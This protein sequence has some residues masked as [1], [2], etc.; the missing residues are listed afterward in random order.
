M[1]SGFDFAGID[2]LIDGTRTYA[3]RLIDAVAALIEGYAGQVVG[4]AKGGHPW[5]NRT[6]AAEAGLN[7]GVIREA[8]GEVVTLY[9]AHGVQ[10][11]IYLENKYGGK[12]GV[13]RTVLEAAYGPLMADLQALLG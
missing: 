2:D 5:A 9:L 1:A 11:G 13:V 6:G 7:S 12:W 4:A 3:D 10:Y 8:A